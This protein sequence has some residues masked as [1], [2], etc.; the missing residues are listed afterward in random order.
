LVILKKT[1]VDAI[2]EGRKTIE[3]RFYRTKHKWL[4]RIEKGDKL[5]L[6]VSSGPVAA[7][8][9][10]EAVKQFG[11]LTAGQITTLKDKYNR[12]ILGDEKYWLEKMNS[13]FG[14]LVWLK[15]VQQIAPRFITK[16]DWRAWVV[17]S[18]KANFG[19]LDH[20]SAPKP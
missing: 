1:Y 14:I 4:S 9:A 2:I 3:S 18:P 12:H 17:L 20:H 5:F 19:L 11:N 6:K 10:V 7:T 15:D 13:R 8:A 16:A